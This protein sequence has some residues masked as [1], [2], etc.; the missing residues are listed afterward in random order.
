MLPLNL[1]PTSSSSETFVIC[2]C[3][4]FEFLQIYMLKGRTRGILE[5][6]SV[7]SLELSVKPRSRWVMLDAPCM[8]DNVFGESVI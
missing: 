4:M 2:L 7:D 1:V 6:V 5:K 8:I 3:R